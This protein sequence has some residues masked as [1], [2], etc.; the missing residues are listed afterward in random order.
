MDLFWSK[1]SVY[2]NKPQK[3]NILLFYFP[4]IELVSSQN[5]GHS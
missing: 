3:T 2:I 1:V 4:K 5:K